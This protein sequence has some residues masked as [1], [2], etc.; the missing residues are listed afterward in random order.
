MVLQEHSNLKTSEHYHLKTTYHSWFLTPPEQSPEEKMGFPTEIKHIPAEK[1]T[2]LKEKHFPAEGCIFE[3][4]I[5]GNRKK[6]REGFEARESRTLVCFHNTLVSRAK[7]WGVL[8]PTGALSYVG[9][10]RDV[11]GVGPIVEHPSRCPLILKKLQ[12]EKLIFLYHLPRDYYKWIPPTTSLV[13][14]FVI[15]TEV[16]AW[17]PVFLCFLPHQSSR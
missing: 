13:V 14:A 9:R 16:W 11:A 3:G 15:L 17:V 6:L 8:F 5:A 2:F 4:R 7:A 12:S 1:S 10:S